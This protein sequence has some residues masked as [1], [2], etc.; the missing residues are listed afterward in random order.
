VD[1]G[2]VIPAIE[3]DALRRMLEGEQH[4]KED[5]MNT[6]ERR[7]IARKRAGW[8]GTYQLCGRGEGW[9]ECRV[10]DYSPAGA[11]LELFGPQ[12]KREGEDIVVRLELSGRLEGGGVQVPG[13]V[14]YR[15]PGSSGSQRVGVELRGLGAEEYSSITSLRARAVAC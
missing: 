8:I 2:W 14:T 1:A 15:A 12:P 9:F 13:V 10:L 7:R 4:A 6:I 11:G 5:L 3:H